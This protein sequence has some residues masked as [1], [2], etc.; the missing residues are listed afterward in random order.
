MSFEFTRNEEWR[1]AMMT[2]SV[3]FVSFFK[4]LSI[5]AC[6]CTSLQERRMARSG[7]TRKVLLLSLF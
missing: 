4:F 3:T 6:K 5:Q 7:V 1:E 2:K